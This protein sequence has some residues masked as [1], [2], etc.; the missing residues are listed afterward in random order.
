NTDRIKLYPLFGIGGGR[1]ALQLQF[2]DNLSLSALAASTGTETTVYKYMPFFD[3]GLGFDVLMKN[4]KPMEGKEYGGVLGIRAGYTQGVGIGNWGYNS[5]TLTDN[6]AYNPGTIYVKANIGFYGKMP[7]G[8]NH[9]KGM[10]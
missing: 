4:P 10:H 3:A 7:K 5:G 2:I 1:V 9:W 6:P 8:F